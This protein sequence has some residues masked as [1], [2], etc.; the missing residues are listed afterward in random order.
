MAV[1]PLPLSQNVQ[2]RALP[3]P[4]RARR[5]R[6]RDTARRTI[7]QLAVDDRVLETLM[8]FDADAAE[9]EPEPDDEEDGPPVVLEFW[10]RKCWS[11]G[12]PGVGL[13]R[14]SSMARRAAIQLKVHRQLVHSIPLDDE[15]IEYLIQGL[16]L[17][18][19]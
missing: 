19:P 16:R 6:G 13:R 12:G 1:V 17:V 11:E 4:P 2:A 14:L 8:T 10:G 18:P 5:R 3:S 7:I 9:L 15:D